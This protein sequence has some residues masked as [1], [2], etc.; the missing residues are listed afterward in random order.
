VKRTAF[1][2]S[3]WFLGLAVGLLVLTAGRSDTMEALERAVYD[4]GMRLAD[5]TPSDRIA[6]IAIDD[7]SL[8]NL[9][10]WPWPRDVHA[11]M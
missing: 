1:W 6:V 5:A 8:A 9:G 10:R 11:R 7:A 4:A 3:D 2:R